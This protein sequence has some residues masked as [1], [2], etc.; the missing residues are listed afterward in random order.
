[1]WLT[2]LGPIVP[3]FGTFIHLGDFFDFSHEEKS[4]GA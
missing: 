1:M 3:I 2:L 4:S